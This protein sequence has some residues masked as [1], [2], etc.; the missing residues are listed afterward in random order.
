METVI[1]KPF[2]K[3]TIELQ[4]KFKIDEIKKILSYNGDTQVNLIIRENNKIAH[5]SLQNSR[6]FDLKDFKA[7][8]A[9]KY[10]SKI[11]V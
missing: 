7:L 10:V 2:S 11:T 8:K 9:K 6:K 5:Y 3:V 1:N 4:N